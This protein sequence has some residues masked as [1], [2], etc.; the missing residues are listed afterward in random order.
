MNA[1]DQPWDS[2]GF[3][4]DEQSS[5]VTLNHLSSAFWVGLMLT[6][7]SGSKREQI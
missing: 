6:L 2:E 1:G 7:A 3:H 5:A 4:L